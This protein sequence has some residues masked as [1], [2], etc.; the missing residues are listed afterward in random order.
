M[1]PL[2]MPGVE[3]DFAAST[4]T[5]GDRR[6][7]AAIIVDP[8][9]GDDDPDPWWGGWA[10][11]GDPEWSRGANFA[12]TLDGE[13]GQIPSQRLAAPT[14]SLYLHG[15]QWQHRGTDHPNDYEVS[16][17]VL[18]RREI[19]ESGA[20]SFSGGCWSNCEPAWAAEHIDRLSRFQFHPRPI[21]P[22]HK[23][24]FRPLHAWRPVAIHE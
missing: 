10:H 19:Y 2:A 17:A 5:L 20:T 16:Y 3:L 9:G 24:T 22:A 21:D 4:I 13:D 6:F 15:R 23:L 7:P 1:N 12:V 14:L 11:T 18:N 8:W